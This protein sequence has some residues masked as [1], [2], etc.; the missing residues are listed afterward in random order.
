[1]FQSACRTLDGTP[2]RVLYFRSTINVFDASIPAAPAPAPTSPM[3]PSMSVDDSVAA[4]I[5]FARVILIFHLFGYVSTKASAS[6][7]AICASAVVTTDA[8]LEFP[9]C[10][11]IDSRPLTAEGVTAFYH[12]LGDCDNVCNNCGANF[13]YKECI[14]SYSRDHSLRY[15]TCCQEGHVW[16]PG[17]E[18]PPGSIKLLLQDPHFMDNKRAYNQMFS[19]TSFSARVDDSI[20]AGGYPYV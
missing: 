1:M 13:W 19:M 18:E 4:S 11:L 17:E 8:R 14:K 9:S 7:S 2:I 15:H 3:L 6:P 10:A 16:I 12:D 5:A 20:N